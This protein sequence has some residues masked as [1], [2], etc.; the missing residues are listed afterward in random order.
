M[1]HSIGEN[2]PFLRSA[3]AGAGEMSA[4]AAFYGNKIRSG[5]RA[6]NAK[7][8]SE[9]SLYWVYGKKTWALCGG[10]GFIG[11]RIN[12]SAKSTG[13]THLSMYSPRSHLPILPLIT[14]IDTS[15]EGQ[16]GAIVKATVSF[17]IYPDI[18]AQGIALKKVQSAFFTPGASLSAQFGWSTYAA[19]A[20]ASKF[21]FSGKVID[22]S[23]SVN[24]D[25]SIN[26]STSVISPGAVA[27][28][29]TGNLS[30]PGSAGGASASTGPSG[31]PTAT[32]PAGGASGGSGGF[33]PLDPKA[34]PV[35][36]VDL[37]TIVEQVMVANQPELY[38][39]SGGSSAG[40]ALG[41][42]GG[43]GAT[44][45]GGAPEEIYGIKAWDTKAAATT[46]NT[47][48]M[49]FIGVGIPWQPDPPATNEVNNVD[50]AAVAAANG[51][52][53]GTDG[54]GGTT[55]TPPIIIGSGG[56]GGPITKPI[57]KP[58]WFVRFG[59]MEAYLTKCIK[60]ATAGKIRFCDIENETKNATGYASAYPMQTIWKGTY[61]KSV[62][63]GGD[64]IGGI[65]FNGDYVKETW[66]S[67]F[68]E[69]NTKV[70]QKNITSFLN[71]LCDRANE[72]SGDFWQLSATVIDKIS[73][74][75]G[76]GSV[77]SALSV[78][79][80]S[81]VTPKGGFGFN[82]SFGRPMLKNVSISC[83]SSSTMGASVMAGGNVD[84]PGEPGASLPGNPA[85]EI[86]ALMTAVETSGINTN[87]GDAM[88]GLLKKKKKAEGAHHSKKCVLFPIDF[89]V[90]IDGCSGWQFCGAIN[91][92][93]KPP[94][95]GGTV[96]AING[97]NHKIDPST[98]DTSIRGIMRKL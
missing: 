87:W 70:D 32:P 22:F 76:T 49:E 36:G 50:E 47:E 51:Q 20:C 66:R 91:T 43:G 74:C 53:G 94:G 27:V 2:N 34:I 79:D 39:G 42:G 48:G 68:N 40:G 77:T 23:W 8:G 67:F 14:G 38:A 96:F 7:T 1:A 93:L 13:S 46:G 54:N 55:T 31:T 89:G 95:Y 64:K 90:T 84:T 62:S 44:P 80:F 41:A 4:R 12:S 10:L 97:V 33:N 11:P 71:K 18:T 73:S 28:G 60:S 26:A 63:L 59:S 81:H 57:V 17:T 52:S 45:A 58:F 65:W 30:K 16:M 24:T 25:V 15:N 35:V 61:N 88:K 78:E 9:Q 21:G 86:A 29:V 72:A 6:G 37:A 19:S 82:A 3:G 92:N 85:G 69:N 83:K 75:G 98:W 5:A 56:S